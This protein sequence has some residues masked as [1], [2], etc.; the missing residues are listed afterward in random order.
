[1][2][3]NILSTYLGEK[4]GNQVLNGSI[5]R[6]DGQLIPAVIWYS[7][8]RDSTRLAG[9][10]ENQQFLNTLNQYFE[11]TAGS[12]ARTG[13]EVL[14]FIGD[15]V[16]AIYPT[17]DKPG[18]KQQACQS[19]A[20][21]ARLSRTELKKV[22]NERGNQG[23]PELQFGIGLHIGDVLFGNIG[24]PE[25]L[26]FSVIGPATNEVAR[27][28]DLSKSLNRPVIASQ[29]FIDELGENWP[30]FGKHHL[31]GVDQPFEVFT[32][33]WLDDDLSN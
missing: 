5:K 13:G 29:R 16:L 18:N 10:Q 22:N 3:H 20:A 7:D 31:R 4:A 2:T 26:E 8:L 15:A 21:A 6:G 24:I 14:R 17:D 11:C 19:A 33:P 23:L 27:L 28:E 25:R 1:M 30:S 12:V 32:A 9:F